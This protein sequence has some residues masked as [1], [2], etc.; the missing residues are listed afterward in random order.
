[1]GLKFSLVQNK[2]MRASLAIHLVALLT[3]SAGSVA[4]KVDYQNLDD[5]TIVAVNETLDSV[6]KTIG[7]EMQITVKA[8]TGL[9]PVI[10]CD[11]QNKP[12][13]RAFKILLGDM[14]YS[15][16]WEESGERLAGLVILS[17]DGEPSEASARQT[18]PQTTTPRGEAAQVV[19]I[20]D[21][22]G[23]DQG[24]GTPADQLNGN[25]QRAEYKSRMEAEQLEMEARMA[26]EREVAEAEMEL[27]RQEEEVAH[28]A[29]MKEEEVRHKALMADYLETYG[30][31]PAQ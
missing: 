13:K 12:V 11:I 8:P 25:P 2:N 3:F 7:K 9:N 10:N 20:S 23:G 17:G 29:R 18:A 22:R 14:S 15:L 6:L 24:A 21:A 30:P 19:S 4:A 1:M 16:L 26:E 5:V 27:R 31:K 28:K